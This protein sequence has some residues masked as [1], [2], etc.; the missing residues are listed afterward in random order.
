MFSAGPGGAWSQKATAS[1]RT[2]SDAVRL[3]RDT[4]KEG[5]ALRKKNER[6]DTTKLLTRLELLAP[7]VGENMG[8]P[9]HRS[10]AL[11][12]RERAELLKDVIHAV[13]L[14]Q[15]P[16]RDDLVVAKSE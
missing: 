10:K 1:G 13:R 7:N 11:R 5:L 12:G 16:R 6:A 2:A 15:G 14:A 9:G 8:Q 3:H 4:T